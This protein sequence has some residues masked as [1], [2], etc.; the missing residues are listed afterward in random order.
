MGK[1]MY[2]VSDLHGCGE[3]YDSIIEYLEQKKGA[4]FYINGDLID[5]GCDSYR[6]LTD[7]K[8][9]ISQKSGIKIH[10]L[11]GEHE[12]LMYRALLELE[13]GYCGKHFDVWMNSGGEA[14]LNGLIESGDIYEK[15]RE[16][17][18][19]LGSLD[20]Y[21]KFPTT[22][23]N[24]D[25]L[26]LVH[27]KAPHYVYDDCH[28]KIADNNRE[29]EDAVS[30]CP[31]GRTFIGNA[32][33]CSQIGKKGYFTI[34]GHTPLFKGDK[35]YKYHSRGNHLNQIVAFSNGLSFGSSDKIKGSYILDMR[36]DL[37]RSRKESDSCAPRIS[38]TEIDCVHI[39]RTNS[40][41]DYPSEARSGGIS[42]GGTRTV[43]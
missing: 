5:Y 39:H 6:I 37:D 15:Y 4:E 28:L 38:N 23:S 19:F 30:L 12:L 22:Q 21:H 7:V 29:V 41:V 33:N 3:V 24:G 43:G 14:T 25:N 42:I 34:V 35:P 2:I 27:A 1:V 17:R 32:A 36:A 16:L 13:S 31:E 26:L 8:N 40:Y 9:H 11:G 20:V 10:Y 18:E